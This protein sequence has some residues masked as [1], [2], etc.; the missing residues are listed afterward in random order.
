MSTDDNADAESK[1]KDGSDIYGAE[2]DGAV[3]ISGDA[4][5]VAD[6]VADFDGSAS[7]DAGDAEADAR[8][9][10]IAGL[11]VDNS[12][13]FKVEGDALL[14]GNGS[15][16]LEANAAA[17]LVA[18]VMQNRQDARGIEVTDDSEGLEIGLGN[19]CRQ[20]HG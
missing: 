8:L 4:A 5:I 14:V 19:H 2:F 18:I 7:T 10:D 16:D 1:S 12:E 3:N 15:F 20:C 11:R 13:T 6:A 9:E 17:H